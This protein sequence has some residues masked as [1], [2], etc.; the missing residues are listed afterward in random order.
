MGR[1]AGKS[2]GSGELNNLPCPMPYAP[3]PMRHALCAMPHAPCPMPHA[4]CPM[5]Y[6]PISVG[7]GESEIGASAG[8]DIGELLVAPRVLYEF[9]R[10]CF[11][12]VSQAFGGH[13][14]YQ[15]EGWHVFGDNGTGTDDTAGADAHAVH[16][17][18]ANADQAAALNIGSV[19]DGAVPDCDA[20]F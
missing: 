4:P 11:G 10:F 8:V 15:R 1:R 16:D 13:A 17:D 2:G 6:A 3:C 14:H 18:C 5:P 20:I 7:C 12:Y 19:N 9:R